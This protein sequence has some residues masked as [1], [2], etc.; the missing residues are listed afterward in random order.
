MKPASVVRV[1]LLIVVT[2]AC[3]ATMPAEDAPP[4]A[5]K[6][7][8]DRDRKDKGTVPKPASTEPLRVPLGSGAADRIVPTIRTWKQ[9]REQNVVMQTRDY[10]CG[11]AALAT[12]AKYYF[13]DT[14][15]ETQ[16]IERILGG[17]KPEEVKDREKNGLSLDDLFAVSEKLGYQAAV[18]RLEAANLKELEAPILVRII[19]DDYKHFV[20]VRGVVEDR[21]W[22]AD[23]MRGNLRIPAGEFLKQW[24]GVALILGKTGFGLPKNHALAIPADERSRPEIQSA[25]RFLSDQALATP[26]FG[27]R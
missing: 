10:S 22:I 20:V 5:D 6:S 8:R 23:P 7:N 18:V 9:L 14:I 13:G 16:I 24:N 3:A 2:V 17:L 27:R 26:T 21:V 11:A 1:L 4:G 19:K 15:T 12:I 25:R